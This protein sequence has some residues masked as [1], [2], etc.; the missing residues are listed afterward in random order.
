MRYIRTAAFILSGL[1]ALQCTDD[2]P[3]IPPNDPPVYAQ[4]IFLSAADSGLTEISL[5][6]SISDTLPPRGFSLYRN[7]AQILTGSLFGRET[8]LVDTAVQFNTSY[9]YSVF[10]TDHSSK[11]DSSKSVMISTLD[12]TSHNYIFSFDTLGDG[13]SSILYDVAIINDTLAYA[14]GEIFL[15]DSTGKIDPF[16][17]NFA[18]WNGR[19]WKVGRITVSYRGNEIIE[20]I[21]SIFAFSPSDIWLSNGV[22]IHGDGKKWNQYHLFDM[23]VLSS[24]DGIIQN[25]WGRSTGKMFFVGRAGTIVTYNGN[26]WQKIESGTTVTINDVWGDR[27]GTNVIA[28]ATNIYETGERKL[29]RINGAVTEQI[30][31][32]PQQRLHSIWFTTMKRLY[33]S[34][35]GVYMFNKG[36]WNNIPLPSQFT[37]RIR[38]THENNIWTVGDFGICARFNGSS[39]KVFPEAALPDGQY[40]GLAVT[41]NMMMAVG[42]VGNRAIIVTAKK[43]ERNTL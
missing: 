29:L 27:T 34:G 20:R 37:K 40:D 41:P 33:T 25:I 3:V 18:Q 35:G 22:P 6:L 21:Y 26:G 5:T 42:Q 19:E 12:T 13:A 38:G 36:V 1:L 23:G 8:V 2:P 9:V 10:R 16:L 24:N 15:K 32:T 39:W 17:Y 31:W 30:N 14:V 28:A 43:L 11:K 7:N 4:S